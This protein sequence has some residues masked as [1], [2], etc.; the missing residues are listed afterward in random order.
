L[1]LEK[2]TELEREGGALASLLEEE[3]DRS[4]FLPRPS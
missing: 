2:F 1:S 4:A 3:Y